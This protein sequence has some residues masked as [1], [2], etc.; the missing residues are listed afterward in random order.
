[1]QIIYS[2]DRIVP[3]ECVSCCQELVALVSVGVIDEVFS[4]PEFDTF[5][6]LGKLVI[7]V[8]S[9]PLFLSRLAEFE[10]YCEGCGVSLLCA[11]LSR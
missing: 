4:V 5:D 7:A 10:D 3:R 1:M 11:G 2:P 8:A 6:A 9:P